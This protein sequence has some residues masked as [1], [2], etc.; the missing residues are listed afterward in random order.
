MRYFLRKEFNQF[1]DTVPEKVDVF[2]WLA[3][4]SFFVISFTFFMYWMFVWAVKNAGTTINVWM[5][6]FLISFMQ[7]MLI[8]ETAQV[9]LIHVFG[10][11][12]DVIHE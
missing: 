2:L 5:A 8:I 4:W 7:D 1:D 6:T 10:V 11:S 3:A 12:L 9:L